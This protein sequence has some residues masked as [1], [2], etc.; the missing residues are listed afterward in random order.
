MAEAEPLCRETLDGTREVK[1]SRHPDTLASVHKLETVL[2]A[3]GKFT[4]A[5]PLFRQAVKTRREVLGARHP[6]TLKS[7]QALMFCL[8]AQGRQVETL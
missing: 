2:H 5:E 1:G 8:L 6:D 4:E 7:T 3:Q